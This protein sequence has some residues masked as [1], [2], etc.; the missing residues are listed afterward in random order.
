M[1]LFPA[2]RIVKKKQSNNAFDGEGARLFGGRWNSKG[3]ACVYVAG[4]ESLA[5]LEVLVHTGARLISEQYRLFEVR[6]SEKDVLRLKELPDNWRAE[7]PPLETAE[8]GDAWLDGSK[9]LALAVPSA[10]VPR[11]WTYLLNP[12][13]AGFNRLV[14]KSR[15]LPFE[16][17]PRL[18]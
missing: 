12:K 1:A 8:I 6:V 9:S 7:L 2:Y 10:V 3:G 17:D 13:H 4:S 11:E 16:F 14:K 15:S 18:S 5:I